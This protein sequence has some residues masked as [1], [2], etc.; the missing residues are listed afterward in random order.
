M[1][2]FIILSWASYRKF[3]SIPAPGRLLLITLRASA[4]IIVLLLLLNP[5]FYSSRQLEIKPNIAVFLDNSES[6][7][8]TKGEYEGLDSYRELLSDL[9]F[10]AITS[11]DFEYYSIGESVTDFSPDSLNATET[12]TNLSDPVQSVLEM[13]DD[14]QAAILI[15]DGII[16]FGRNPSINASNSS[17]PLYTIAIGDTSN[18]RDVSVSNV[19]TN[20]TGYTNTNHIIEAEISQ[21][22]FSN[23]TV[24]VSLLS[25][26]EVLKEQTI[27]FETDDQVIQTTFEIELQEAGLKQ[28]Q[29]QTSPLVD[30]WTESN[31]SRLFTI[32]VLD[33]KVKI[34]HI[35]F[36]VHPDVK[37]VRSVIQQDE[38]NELTTLT[39]MGRDQF[40][41]ELPDDSDFNLIIIHG[42]PNTARDFSFLDSIDDTPS[43]LFDLSTSPGSVVGDQFQALINYRTNQ[44]SQIF[45]NQLLEADQQ[46]ILELPQISLLEAPPLYAPLRNELSELQ[47]E[48]LYTI[49]YNGL[50]TRFPV[51]SVLERGNIRRAHVVPWGWYKWTQS[52]NEQEREY[53]TTLLSNL[54]NWTASN[55]DNR[56][57]RITPAKKT[58]STAETPIINGSLQNERGDPEDEGIIELQIQTPTGDFRTFN[59]E[60]AGNGN[61]R[62]DLPRL[63]EGLYKYEAVARKGDREIERRTGEFLV[64]N[65]SSELTNTV[66]NDGLLKSISLNSDGR[67]FTYQNASAL[68]DSLEQAGLFETQTQLV[69]NYSFPVRSVYWFVITL[70]LLGSEWLLRKY[71]S[72]P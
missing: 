18:V 39:W 72:L 1:L 5:Y 28:Y 19:L 25:D 62:L 68:W 29:I 33:S 30:E 65:S 7:G 49:N 37:A 41:E 21:S 42:K 52:T 64:S 32:D 12:Q 63:S 36:E 55:P 2:G 69:E 58:F 27:T 70:L 17:I 9:D 38:S 26:G 56:K 13:E 59:M 11:A 53:A 3:K 46:P 60:N 20:S 22:G 24:T 34:L 4:L 23:N 67:Y 16:T 15:S 8:I 43:I 14:V 71:Y 51:L 54:I 44:V 40:I 48:T 61:Y 6:V 57:L 35:A 50:D 47:S 66:R 31:N 10:T 45:L